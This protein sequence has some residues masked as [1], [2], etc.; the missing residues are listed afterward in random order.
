[1]SSSEPVEKPKMNVYKVETGGA[2]YHFAATTPEE[3]EKVA[4]AGF[5]DYDDPESI[6][7]DGGI[8]VELVPP[9]VWSDWTYHD[10][11]E[12]DVNA[13]FSSLVARTEEPGVLICSEWP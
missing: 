12:G 13:S 9:E 3:A 5:E 7:Q 11:G 8:S 1:M 2:T 10:D 4:W 6:R